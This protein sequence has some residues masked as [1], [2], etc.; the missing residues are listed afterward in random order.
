MAE[1]QRQDAETSDATS[2]YKRR[3][4]HPAEVTGDRLRDASERWYDKLQGHELDAIGVII[5][6]LDEIAE[7][8]R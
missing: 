2:R 5:N 7:G 3:P 8:N 6:A 4:R 1:N